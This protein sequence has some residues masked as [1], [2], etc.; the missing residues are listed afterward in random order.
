MP[1]RSA[2]QHV[3]AA[4]PADHWSEGAF[5]LQNGRSWTVLSVALAG[6]A[7]LGATRA[8]A[9]CQG[10]LPGAGAPATAGTFKAAT[11]FDPD[12]PGPGSANLVVGGSFQGLGGINPPPTYLAR[13]DG[14][15]WGTFPI[16]FFGARSVNALAVFDL[17]GDGPNPAKLIVG[18]DFTIGQPPNRANNILATGG[19]VYSI[20]SEGFNGEVDALSVFDPDGDGP[21]TAALY[22]G[23]SFRFS[24]Q[25]SVG[26]VARWGGSTWQ[27][28]GALAGTVY[29]LTSVDL[30][31]PGPMAPMLVAGGSS[32]VGGSGSGVAFFDGANWVNFGN[33]PQG[34]VY[35]LDVFD[36]DGP[37][38]DPAR[39]VAAGT[40]T[41]TNTGT[42]LPG[43]AY[44]NG[45]TWLPIAPVLTPS[46]SG[47]TIA[48][49][50]PDGEGP[51][52]A[53]LYLSGLL[54]LRSLATARL[55]VLGDSGWE[56][57]AGTDYAGDIYSMQSLVLPGEASA[58]AFLTG[59]FTRTQP[60]QTPLNL[61]RLEGS[62]LRPFNDGFNYQVQDMALVHLQGAPRIA[63]CGFGRAPGIVAT[64][65]IAIFDG[66]SWSALGPQGGG[67]GMT[68]V[69]GF[70]PDDDGPATESI[71]AGGVFTEIGGVAA[72]HVAMYDGTHWSAMGAGIA[73]IPTDFG[74]LDPDGPGP[75]PKRLFA[76]FGNVGGGPGVPGYIYEWNGAQWEQLPDAFVSNVG[77]PQTTR[78]ATFDPDG[79]GPGLPQLVVVGLFNH[80]GGAPANNV[81]AYDGHEWHA[82]GT[83]ITSTNPQAVFAWDRNGDGHEVVIVAGGF[84]S[85]GGVPARGVAVWDG[86]AWSAL[87]SGFGTSGG[88][89]EHPSD[90]CVFD[91]DLYAT[92]YFRVRDG[93]PGEGIAR[94]NGTDWEPVGAGLG[95]GGGLCAAVLPGDD[96]RGPTMCIG[97]NFQT[98]GGLASA[99]FARYG[100]IDCCPADFDQNGTLD[101][102][103]FFAFLFSFF[104]EG[105]RAD[106][107][108]DGS[109]NSQ[110]LFDF[111]GAFFAGC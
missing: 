8:D 1:F 84:T 48:A 51:M 103:D 69:F 52:P 30:D 9:Q 2:Y 11:L 35:S 66:Q 63:A 17:D 102:E 37:G 86:S 34:T 108:A 101:S 79:D 82:L 75:N 81:A 42:T 109:V 57:V 85:A 61:A 28:V 31:G 36:L 104:S 27:P 100:T 29:A 47:R 83:G 73:D 44:F 94:W 96:A 105:P 72:Q 56:L 90:F 89:Q 93:G 106:F 19:G 55:V 107:N 71:I 39:L 3:P 16:Q 41:R 64:N 88:F 59:T 58:T 54:T 25:R 80:V 53:R 62:E 60:E 91:G 26:T 32:L 14:A 4:A 76:T 10:W 99:Y 38:G 45:S 78:M 46:S 98:A 67:G 77:P 70:D 7:I 68:A 95:L 74:A 49:I 5:M 33:Y 110:D 43:Q 87:G 21:A 97:G 12:G 22:A 24:G 50:D 6:W 13:W 111:L 23:G 40:F 92:G 65:G 15:A 20:L 18:G